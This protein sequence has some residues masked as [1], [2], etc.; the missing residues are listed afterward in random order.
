V[1]EAAKSVSKQAFDAKI[2][3]LEGLRAKPESA[4][5]PLRKSLKD[6]NNFLVSKAASLAGE[7]FLSD[8][9]PDL[10][11]VFDRSLIDGPKIDPQC[12]AKNAI[13]KALKDLSH[14]DA[15]VYLKGLRHIQMEPVWGGQVDTAATLRG[16]CALALI[17]CQL[18][19]LTMLTHLAETLADPEKTV[20]VDAAVALSRAGI[21]EA[22]PL[23]RFKALS[24][25]PEPEVIGQCL[26]SLLQ[27]APR[28]SVAF[29][30]RFLTHKHP[31]DI[32]AEAASALA[33]SHEPAA[34][35]AL[36]QM[37]RAML[38]PELRAALL[39]F[40]A[41]SPQREAAEFLASLETKEGREALKS[42]RYRDD[43]GPR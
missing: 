31:D 24:G 32:R 13:A 43:F 37:W 34:V 22:A 14:H 2:V 38:S 9:I 11:A 40:L 12:C 28:D 8:L 1:E 35:D 25:D 18:D 26:H 7:L 17:D 10:L 23:L 15:E 5:E 33:Q 3:A 36:K 29:A 27:M 42:S 19:D 30:Q 39:A 16:T 41:A 6:R 21:P 4:A 20:R